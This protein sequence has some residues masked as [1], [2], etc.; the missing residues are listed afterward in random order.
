MGEL[1][2]QRVLVR[3]GVSR[4][5]GTLLI[6]D[7]KRAMKHFERHPIHTPLSHEE[8]GGFRH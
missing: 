5:L 3:H 2:I 1:S 8:A 4:D 6:D 7:I